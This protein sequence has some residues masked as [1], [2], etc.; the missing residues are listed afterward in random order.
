MNKIEVNV[1]VARANEELDRQIRHYLKEKNI[2]CINVMGSPGSGKTTII[3]RVAKELG[4]ETVAVIQGDLESDVDKER[5]QEQGIATHQINT[6]TG[7]HLNAKIVLDAVK[8]VDFTNKKYLIIENVGNLVCPARKK[9]GQDLNILASST[10][11]GSDKPKK[12]PII[13]IE[14]QVLIISKY[15]LKDYVDFNEEE[16][17]QTISK[18]NGQMTI[19]KTTKKDEGSFKEIANYIRETS[20]LF[21]TSSPRTQSNSENQMPHH[22]ISEPTH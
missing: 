21:Y 10:T 2:F 3:E 17:L 14:S 7:C 4:K 19:F 15:D 11:E 16:Y 20:K 22:T 6:H 13:F 1:P 8:H 12:Y 9:I 18:I 5:L